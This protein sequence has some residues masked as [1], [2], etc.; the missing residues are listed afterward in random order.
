LIDVYTFAVFE[1]QRHFDTIRQR[2]TK[3]D[4]PDSSVCSKKIEDVT[5]VNDMRT[6]LID[7]INQ[8]I[9]LECY[10]ER[11]MDFMNAAFDIEF[12]T[13]GPDTDPR[14]VCSIHGH[15]VP[16]VDQRILTIRI[17]P[18]HHSV[19]EL[20]R[21]SADGEIVMDGSRGF[22]ALVVTFLIDRKFE[23]VLGAFYI[24][25]HYKRYITSKIVIAIRESHI[26]NS[27]PPAKYVETILDNK[28]FM[29]YRL[30]ELNW[31]YSILKNAIAA[32]GVRAPSCG[33]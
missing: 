4:D 6:N 27:P 1:G 31:S 18:E 25:R 11:L 2:S 23:P 7:D 20:M 13:P 15:V 14:S 28:F 10:G 29:R 33:R 22:D 30:K 17:K 21:T 16:E 5:R 8:S 24:V 12:T 3:V 9:K 32:V 19:Q 26:I